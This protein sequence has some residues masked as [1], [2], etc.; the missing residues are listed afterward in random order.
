MRE[1]YVSA[2]VPRVLADV[3]AV[4]VVQVVRVWVDAL[5][6]HVDVRLAPGLLHEAVVVLLQTR[7]VA[8]VVQRRGE[9][10]VGLARPRADTRRLLQQG[11]GGGCEVL[12]WGLGFGVFLLFGQQREASSLR[13]EGRLR[14]ALRVGQGLLAGRPS[15]EGLERA[16]QLRQSLQTGGLGGPEAGFDEVLRLAV[17]G[18]PGGERGYFLQLFSEL[19]SEDRGVLAAELRGDVRFDVQLRQSR[20]PWTAVP[21]PAGS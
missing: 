3:H 4:E 6:D 2:Q 9:A 19:A 16:F 10:F 18:F 5:R 14:L 11:L 17:D 1:S 15:F 13:E 8:R 21:A 7:E 12:V 20:S